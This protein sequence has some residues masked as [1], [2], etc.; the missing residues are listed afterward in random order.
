M[1][2]DRLAVNRFEAARLLSISL[3]TLDALVARGELRGRRVG[4]RIVFPVEE[5]HRFL[6]KDHPLTETANSVAP[7]GNQNENE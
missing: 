4:R 3:R 1:Q 2:T 5:L 6:R 7:K